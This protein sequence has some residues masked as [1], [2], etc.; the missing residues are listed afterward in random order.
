M[1]Q[2][3]F[4]ND[5]ASSSARTVGWSVDVWPSHITATQHGAWV[6]RGTVFLGCSKGPGVG[7]GCP[8]FLGSNLGC[9]LHSVG[10]QDPKASLESR[11][12]KLGVALYLFSSFPFFFCFLFK[13]G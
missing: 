6:L 2:Y 1:F 7:V 4:I 10:T 12:G 5:T 11:E 9:L 8:G 13:T 3:V